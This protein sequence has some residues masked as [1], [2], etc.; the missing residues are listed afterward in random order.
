MVTALQVWTGLVHGGQTRAEG[1]GHLLSLLGGLLFG[2]FLKQL[3]KASIVLAR[4]GQQG[5][6]VLLGQQA[7]AGYNPVTHGCEEFS[8]R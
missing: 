4:F 6:A 1:D 3:L 7:R 5:W 2:A 8:P